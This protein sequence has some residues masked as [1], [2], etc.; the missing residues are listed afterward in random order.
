MSQKLGVIS[1][2]V[3]LLGLGSCKI[4][5]LDDPII[6]PL[7]EQEFT[8]DL[9]E[10]LSPTGSTWEIRLETVADEPCENSTILT[11]YQKIGQNLNLTIFDILAPENCNPV[12]EPATGSEELLE[13]IEGDYNLSVELQDIVINNGRLLVTEDLLQVN[14]DTEDG[15]GWLHTELRRVPTG[16]LWGYVAYESGDQQQEADS[17]IHSVQAIAAPLSVVN[18]YYGHFTVTNGGTAV[19][20]NSRPEGMASKSFLFE[21]DNDTLDIT[22]LVEEF[23]TNAPAG[24]TVEVFNYKGKIW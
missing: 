7:V 5:N 18:G 17:F 20:V 9:W 15:I 10:N 16:A 23:R 14:M 11:D 6:I 2:A 13:V 8:L 3:L 19:T 21:Y 1:L 22:Q 4:E 12:S 24:M